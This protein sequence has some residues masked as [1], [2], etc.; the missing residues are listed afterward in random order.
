MNHKK[1]IALCAGLVVVI[2]LAIPV[3]TQDT[4]IYYHAG[5]EVLGIFKATQKPGSFTLTSLTYNCVN[6]VPQVS[7]AW[8]TSAGAASYAFQRK[9]PWSN[10]WETT[11]VTS[12]I[13][14]T[15]ATWQAGYDAGTYSY[16][17]QA[18]NNRGSA[19]TQTMQINIGLC[20]TA[21]QIPPPSSPTPTSTSTTT[22]AT[23][24]PAKILWGA[25]VG[26]TTTDAA[27]FE[28]LV[29][30]KINIQAIFVDM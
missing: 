14:F 10:Q 27:A 8:T 4:N 6:N 21:A 23:S 13:F 30:K 16:R 29:G 5:E 11:G 19:I 25:Y 20:P 3:I 2:V 24:T 26:D 15:D 12:N 22:P 9:Y 7:G 28:S 18:T 1:I 17:V